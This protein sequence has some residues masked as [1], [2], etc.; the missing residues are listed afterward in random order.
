M[1]NSKTNIENGGLGPVTSSIE[2]V[3]RCIPA[4]GI[5]FGYC[6]V[7]LDTHRKISLDNVVP[8]SVN[9]TSVRYSIETDSPNFSISHS[10]GKLVQTPES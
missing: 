6:S 2:A 8:R 1:N 4:A 3:A 7:S 5:D 10:N 9:G